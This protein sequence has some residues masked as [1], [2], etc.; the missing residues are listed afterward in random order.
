MPHRGTSS[1]SSTSSVA[2]LPTSSLRP[3]APAESLRDTPPP[4]PS[5]W[6]VPEYFSDLSPFSITHFAA[7]SS[8]LAIVTGTVASAPPAITTSGTGAY[9]TS[10]N[11]S[12]TGSMLQLLYPEGSI[13]PANKPQGGAEFYAAPL[14]LSQASNVTFEYDVFF[15]DDFDFVRGGKLPGLFGGHE[16][17]SG[18][19]SALNCFSTRLMW[20]SGGKGELYLYA[21]KD[22]QTDELCSLPPQSI[23]DSTYGLSIAR[24]S[25]SYTLGSWTHVAQ[26]VALNS[27]GVPNGGFYLEVDGRPVID[28]NDVYYRGKTKP[29]FFGGHDPEWASP[30]DQYVWF[31]GFSI[32][33]NA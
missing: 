3:S 23:C 16:T 2:S 18:G 25:F 24:G 29:T 1:A 27:P 15:P 30:R 5:A 20:R 10:D 8:N 31:A 33:I 22:K 19:D 21:P 7:G 17:C 6:S 13:N 32:R 14:D 11:E 12:L 9:I 26:T 28:R 4:K